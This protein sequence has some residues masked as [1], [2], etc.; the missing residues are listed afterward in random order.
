M[1]PHATEKIKASGKIVLSLLKTF[2]VLHLCQ[3][4]IKLDLQQS[5][6]PTRVIILRLHLFFKPQQDQ[7][8]C[9]V[10]YERFKPGMSKPV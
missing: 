3:L 1:I 9:Y 2:F 7:S 5:H 6:T 4:N 10:Y 8:K